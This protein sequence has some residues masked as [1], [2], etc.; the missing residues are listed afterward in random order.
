M[1]TRSLSAQWNWSAEN[2]F[3]SNPDG[4]D[5]WQPSGS[6]I[7]RYDP[8]DYSGLRKSQSCVYI[9]DTFACPASAQVSFFG[10]YQFAIAI[11]LIAAVY[12]IYALTKKKNSKHT[13]RH[14]KI[15]GKKRKK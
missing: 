10:I 7:F 2:S 13:R 6:E 15:T 12:L 11:A 1:L 3:N 8:L 4:L 14:S 9:E 5:Y